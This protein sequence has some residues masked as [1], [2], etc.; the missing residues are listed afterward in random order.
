MHPSGM[1]AQGV[2]AQTGM[3]A[4]LGTV[5]PAPDQQ[6]EALSARICYGLPQR[7]PGH[8]CAGRPCRAARARSLA[9]GRRWHPSEAT[10]SRGRFWAAPR[11]G[12]SAAAVRRAVGVSGGEAEAGTHM[13]PSGE[14]RRRRWIGRPPGRLAPAPGRSLPARWAR[15]R[16]PGPARACR[17]RPGT[18]RHKRPGRS[19]G[20]RPQGRLPARCRSPH[21]AAALGRRPRGWEGLEGRLEAWRRV[22]QPLSP[23]Q[24]SCPAL[25]RAG[26]FGQRHRG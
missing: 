5:L 6:S 11:S 20:A 4:P 23:L 2:A 8:P 25:E 24:G 3:R 14:Q 7:C 26:S 18:L 9:H 16:R 21:R 1:A 17:P 15:R 12:G 19:A 10:S 22:W 13:Q